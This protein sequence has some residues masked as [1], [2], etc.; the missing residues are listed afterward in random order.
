VKHL[1]RLVGPLLIAAACTGGDQQSPTAPGASPS[2]NAQLNASGAASTAS[3]TSVRIVDLG[4]LPS[5][6]W[7]TIAYAVNGGRV[8]VGYSNTGANFSGVQH[9]V[10][11]QE[12]TFGSGIWK[13][14][15]LSSVI[16]GSTMSAATAINA[17]GDVAGWMRNSAGADLAFLLPSVGPLATIA[18]PAGKNATY[19]TGVNAAGAVVGYAGLTPDNTGATVRAF[20]YENGTTVLLPSLSGRSVANAINDDR[21]VV[22]YSVDAANVAR[23]VKWT[24]VGGNWQIAMLPGNANSVASAISSTGRIAG[25]GCPTTTPT[26]CSSMTRAYFWASDAA[27]PTVLGTLGGNSSQ[28]RGVN[29]AGDIAGESFT[30]AGLQRAFFSAADSGVLTDLG[31]LAGGSGSSAAYAISG[32]LVVG[33]SVAG[34]GRLRPFHAAVWILP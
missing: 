20:Y 10:R 11:W 25:T 4:T 24:Y 34:S 16:T 17:N 2:A 32:N 29:D 7:P 28:G 8:I 30:K 1:T 33:E 15:D 13:I 9:A 3:A 31:S 21:T 6:G 26:N 18:P 23:A 12:A 27:T 19:A 5:G 22:G 14:E